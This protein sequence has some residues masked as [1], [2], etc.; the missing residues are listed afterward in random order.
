MGIS[1]ENKSEE[2]RRQKKRSVR[3]ALRNLK[4]FASNKNVTLITLV[5][6]TIVIILD[7]LLKIFLGFDTDDVT[8]VPIIGRMYLIGRDNGLTLYLSQLSFTFIT[9]SVMSVLS[10]SSVVIYWENIVKKK[11]IEPV[12]SCF[13]SY[14]TYSFSTVLFGGIAALL[15]LPLLFLLFF[16]LDIFVLMALTY[17]MIDVYFRHEE[18]AI[19]LEKEFVELVSMKEGSQEELKRNYDR[20]LKIT[21]N[22]RTNTVLALREH[23]SPTI[24]ENLK[25]YARNFAFI[26]RRDIETLL[27][28]VDEIN[29][30][31]YIEWFD[32][33]TYISFSDGIIPDNKSQISISNVMCNKTDM[34]SFIF[35]RRILPLFASFSD[36]ISSERMFSDYKRFVQRRRD[37]FRKVNEDSYNRK[38]ISYEDSKTRN[39]LL[40]GLLEVAKKGNRDFL[41]SFLWAF[42]DTNVLSNYD[43]CDTDV[44]FWEDY[45]RSIPEEEA[46]ER[47][48]GIYFITEVLYGR[49]YPECVQEAVARVWFDLDYNFYEHK[50]YEDS[51]FEW[52]IEDS[53]ENDFLPDIDFK[54]EVEDSQDK[55][56]FAMNPPIGLE[57]TDGHISENKCNDKEKKSMAFFC[58]LYGQKYMGWPPEN[59][60]CGLFTSAGNRNYSISFAEGK[61]YDNDLPKKN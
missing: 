55:D 19:N 25:F 56:D 33:Y 39:I 11:L 24:E 38:E 12:W 32:Y 58:R 13:F 21:S 61:K 36:L 49:T 51:T 41:S 22:L 23:D 5:I 31:D 18:K 59:D 14:T 53:D 35:D 60:N 7:V 29:I 45:F 28:C 37:I 27:K 1:V 48:A 17:S 34:F 3:G 9:I 40:E 30:T 54:I 47:L 26:P 16:I 44:F 15:G 8:S 6:G 57:N 43:D 46:K 52:E 4:S 2:K 10:D 20:Y 50:A 42:E